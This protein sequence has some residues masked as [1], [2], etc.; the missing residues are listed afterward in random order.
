M[1][2]ES[3]DDLLGLDNVY[4]EETKESLLFISLEYADYVEQ[5]DTAVRNGNA[6]NWLRYVP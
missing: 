1:D 5:H 2:D 6:Y 3:S 4:E